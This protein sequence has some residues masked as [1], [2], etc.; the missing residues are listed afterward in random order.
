[1][2]GGTSMQAP[3]DDLPRH[4]AIIMDGNGRWAKRRGLPRIEGHR[5]G[6]DSVREVTRAARELGIQALTLYAF[7]SQNWDRPLEEVRML[8]ALLRDYLVDERPEIL[9]NGIRLTTIGNTERLPDFVR[10]PLFALQEESAKNTGMT[11]CL[12]LS[13]GGREAIVDAAA[14]LV[15]RVLAGEIRVQDVNQL[16]FAESLCTHDL[17]PLDLVV[18]TS[19]EQRLS[20]FL[21]WEVAYAELY[22][23]DTLWPDFKRP[24]LMEALASYQGRERRFGLTSEQVKLRV[25]SPQ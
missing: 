12:A 5:K 13:Y 9:G 3:S 16:S 2:L 21:L 24:E 20:N 7:S 6:A 4:V 14:K 17:P 19:G 23:T 1:M 8:M 11:L 18:R 22:F 25:I 10:E 15:E